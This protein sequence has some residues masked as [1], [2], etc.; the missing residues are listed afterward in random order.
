M[1]DKADV[2]ITGEKDRIAGVRS[3]SLKTFD[4][5]R[6]SGI[7]VAIKAN[8]STARPLSRSTH[9]DTLDTVC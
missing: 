4:M 7:S 1:M 6:F 9:I 5:S 3:V 8:F 2:F